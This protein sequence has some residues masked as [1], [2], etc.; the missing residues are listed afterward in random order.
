MAFHRPGLGQQHGRSSLTPGLEEGVEEGIE[1]VILFFEKG[2][3]GKSGFD[4]FCTQNRVEE[5]ICKNRVEEPLRSRQRQHWYCH[6]ACRFLVRFFLACRNLMVL[7]APPCCAC[8]PGVLLR[9][10]WCICP[11]GWMTLPWAVTAYGCRFCKVVFFWVSSLECHSCSSCRC[12]E[13]LA[14]CLAGASFSAVCSDAA[15]CHSATV[16]GGTCPAARNLL[17]WIA[18]PCRPKHKGPWHGSKIS[19]ERWGRCCKA[20]TEIHWPCQCPV[21]YVCFMLLPLPWHCGQH[22]TYGWVIMHP[23]ASWPW[24]L[25]LVS[26]LLCQHLG[27]GLVPLLVTAWR[28]SRRPCIRGL[29]SCLLLCHSG[30][31]VRTF[32]QRHRKLSA[33]L[34]VAVLLDVQCRC[35]VAICCALLM[36][37]M[38]SYLRSFN[39]AS[40]FLI[41]H[42]LSYAVAPTIVTILMG[43]FIRPEKALN[44]GWVWPLD[45]HTSSHSLDFH[46]CSWAKG[47]RAQ[48]FVGRGWF[49]SRWCELRAGAKAHEHS[50]PLRW[51]DMRGG[52]KRG[53]CDGWGWN[54]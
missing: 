48:Q 11:Y 33:T 54:S 50:T 16:T 17:G 34:P 12:S 31:S 53:A 4:D 22:L 20:W 52:Q 30:S 19:Y 27:L 47:L 14:N 41:L 32:E 45:H 15:H 23:M 2:R 13:E 44:L 10:P 49:K 18:S 42:L 9:F 51:R 24:S 37:S 26:C 29:E 3:S 43:C 25:V 28:D 36:T 46:L 35:R 39:A 7:W 8:A 21:S 6:W 5:Q 1:F 38:P 40:M